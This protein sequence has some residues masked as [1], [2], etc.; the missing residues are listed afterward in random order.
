MVA[1]SMQSANSHNHL[2]AAAIAY[3]GETEELVSLLLQFCLDNS[4]QINSNNIGIIFDRG[5]GMPN[6]LCILYILYIY[7]YIYYNII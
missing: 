5:L 6:I 4:I 2:I 1:L 3:G 7:I